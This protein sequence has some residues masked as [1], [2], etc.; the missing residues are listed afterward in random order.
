MIETLKALCKLSG[1]SGFET[2]VREYLRAQ[3]EPCADH[4]VE[5]AT[6]NLIV[7]KKGRVHVKNPPLLCAHMDE[8]GLLVRRADDNG[9]AAWTRAL[10]RARPSCSARRPFRASSGSSP[11]I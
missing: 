11:S 8:V 10:R 7:F 5:D 3:A 4:V 2:D 6:G 9:S 1:P